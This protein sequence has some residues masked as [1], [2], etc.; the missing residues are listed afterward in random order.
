V[1]CDV[2]ATTLGRRHL[3]MIY[4]FSGELVQAK[5][6]LDLALG[7]SDVD[8][9]ANELP[10]SVLNA[11]A[12]VSVYLALTIWH[13]G[14]PDQA[15]EL[16]R[17]A[18][19]LADLSGHAIT[20]INVRCLEA[21]LECYRSDP[22]A[23]LR[24]ANITRE[25]GR[26]HG[27]AYYISAAE[28][29]ANWATAR[30]HSHS[31]AANALRTAMERYFEEGNGIGAP[32]YHGLLAELAFAAGDGDSALELIDKA[33]GIATQTGERLGASYFNRL[34]GDI[35]LKQDHPEPAHAEEAYQTAI[36]V[37]KEQGARS[38]ELLGAL[39]LAKLYQST[40]RPADAHAVLALALEGFA[41]T[42]QMPE[43][44]EAQVLLERLA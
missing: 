20:I 4:L 22:V 32:L 38:Y 8:R 43:I 39:S 27:M 24:V 31:D 37:A 10:S 41:P 40:G 17:E 42:P 23:T 29:L 7:A 13:L 14:G 34:R 44:A 19:T 12:A 26:Q 15:R 9:A 18:I 6:Q 25:L 30:L 2:A 5:R 1:E 16:M 33:L 21:F 11:R 3:G 36:A 28:V 35:L